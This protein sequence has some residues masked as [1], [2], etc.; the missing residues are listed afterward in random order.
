[1]AHYDDDVLAQAMKAHGHEARFYCS[2]PG[3]FYG[4]NQVTEGESMMQSTVSWVVR[5][6]HKIFSLAPC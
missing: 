4:Y 3:I 2:H 1:M 5:K 6:Q